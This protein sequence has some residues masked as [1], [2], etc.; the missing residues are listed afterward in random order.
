MWFDNIL[1]LIH[2]GFTPMPGSPKFYGL[3]TV[4]VRVRDRASVAWYKASLGLQVV[5]ED[6]PG[7]LVVFNVGR[8]DS[9][10]VCAVGEA[11]ATDGADPGS[12]PVLEVNDAAAHQ[13]ELASRGVRVS[14]LREGRG[15]LSVAFWDP[16]GN[17]LEAW[18]LLEPSQEVGL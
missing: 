14:D 13:R 4:V 5:F 18:Q 10:I 16:E 7:G 2:K 11:D 9:L 1:D 15:H 17:R 12:C 3:N 6:T 8:G